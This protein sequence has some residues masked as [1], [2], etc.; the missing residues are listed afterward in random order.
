MGSVEIDI[1]APRFPFPDL[2]AL[3]VEGGGGETEQ[4]REDS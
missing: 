2:S 4:A 3:P 1:W